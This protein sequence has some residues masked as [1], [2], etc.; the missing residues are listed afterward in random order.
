MD[1]GEGWA[2]FQ[3]L[4]FVGYFGD[5]IY[6]PFQGAI[7]GSGFA[8]VFLP[9]FVYLFQS[10]SWLTNDFVLLKVSFAYLTD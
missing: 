5:A 9:Y 10:T 8:S 4:F 7:L 3:E 6:F 2:A 1:S